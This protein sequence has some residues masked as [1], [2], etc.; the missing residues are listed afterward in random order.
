MLFSKRLALIGLFFGGLFLTAC[1]GTPSRYDAAT[2]ARLQTKFQSMT[3]VVN[4]YTPKEKWEE[5]DQHLLTSRSATVSYLQEKGIFKQVLMTAPNPTE[6]KVVVVDALLNDFRIVHGTARFF[7]GA[8]AGSSY[9]NFDVRLTDG[10]GGT[11]IA[12]KLIESANNAYGAAWTGGS[13][14]RSLPQDMGGVLG[15]YVIQT[16]ENLP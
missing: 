1:A 13:S 6:G 11:P 9:M 10:A 7:F 8:M 4:P 3:V 15:E 5:V 2:V 14:D 16:L 12:S